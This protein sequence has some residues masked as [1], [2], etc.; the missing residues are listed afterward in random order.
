LFKT[1]TGTTGNDNTGDYDGGPISSLKLTSFPTNTNAIT[2]GA[3][4]YINGGTC[5]IGL[6]CSTWPGAGLTI[7]ATN[8]TPDV[9]VSIDPIDGNSTSSIPFVSID[10]AGLEDLSEGKVDVT[11]IHNKTL[12]IDD[13]NTTYQ[14]SAVSGS[15]TTNDFDPEGDDQ[16]FG[17]FLNQDGSGA[18]ITTGDSIL[19]T[20]T[21][22][23]VVT[24]GKLDFATD[25]SY[26]FTPADSFLGEITIP[27]A[28][29]DDGNPVAC[30]TALLVINVKPVLDPT[31]DGANSIFAND[32]DI[33]SYG[34]AVSSIAMTNDGDPEGDTIVIASYLYDSNG[35]GT[36]DAAGTLDATINIGGMDE[37]GNAIVNVGSLTLDDSTG[38]YTFTPV[39]GFVGTATV[40]YT[41]CDDVANPY[42]ACEDAFINITVY[43]D[44]GAANDP[45]LAGDDFATTAMNVTARGSWAGNDMDYNGD[46]IVIN[47]SDSID[48]DNLSTDGT[49]AISTLTTKK[50]GTVKIFANG[51]YEYTPPTNY[52]GPDQVG[53]EICDVTTVNPQPL[54]DSATIYLMV[55]P[56]VRDYGDLPK[57]THGIAYN[58]FKDVDNDGIPEGSLPIWL[59]TS[60]TNEDSTLV[61][62][63]ASGDADDG[64]IFPAELDSNVNN[65]FK[66]IV[67]STVG[68]T[69]V[70]YA[71]YFDWDEDGS[72]E[73]IYTGHGTTG[74][75]D[76]VD[77]S[78]PLPSG[79]DGE[80]NVRLR[81]ALAP[82][83]LSPTGGINN[84]ETEDYVGSITPV[85]VTLTY[86]KAEKLGDID[87]LLTWETAMELNNEKFEVYKSVDQGQTYEQIGEVQG[88]GTTNELIGYHYVDVNAAK[89]RVACYKLRQVD[90][91][92]AFEWTDMECLNW[93][94]EGQVTIYPNPA[95]AVVY[96]PVPMT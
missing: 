83:D 95:N 51:E 2:V 53:Y 12:A 73:A 77:V 13:D 68:G 91:D 70:Y 62:A 31:V 32:D 87:A 85:P 21:A 63:A 25:G 52:I 28:T 8:G 41:L 69:D 40:K 57:G 49:T 19:G 22:G 54:C 86:F 76:T 79:E 48:L 16:T 84:G 29:C 88:S 72:F 90:Y 78:V 26:T 61:G 1:S 81:V 34:D 39:D 55:D 9:S 46:S 6:T 23:N 66:V 17:S 50:G 11:F 44:N 47:G 67:N 65:I 42:K 94:I 58:I 5:P 27:Y 4:T 18:T 82:G 33:V 30:D 74:S 20:D 60:V 10:A 24:G 80:F 59:G 93:S 15:V 75:P 38:A 3:T 92:G 45:P 96:V 7:A 36:P 43:D 37:N 71:L 14:D 35:D 56:I 64:L 89:D